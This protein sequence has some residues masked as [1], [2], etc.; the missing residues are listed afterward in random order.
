MS[1]CTT[2]VPYNTYVQHAQTFCSQI[3]CGC[4]TKQAHTMSICHDVST[5]GGVS[6]GAMPHTPLYVGKWS[7]AFQYVCT[8]ISLLPQPPS[9]WPPLSVHFC[10]YFFSYVILHVHL[11]YW[12]P[13]A[14]ISIIQFTDNL[15]LCWQVS[16]YPTIT[17]THRAGHL[18]ISCTRV[19]WGSLQEIC[20][21][22]LGC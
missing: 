11:Q 16:I 10:R 14:S 20:H 7:L 6:Y 18:L 17:S 5:A 21:S 4:N 13:I 19:E 3:F 2:S 22:L 12:L 9:F 15:V 8:S 1:V